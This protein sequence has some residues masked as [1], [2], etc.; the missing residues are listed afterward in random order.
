MGGGGQKEKLSKSLLPT[1][2]FKRQVEF[3]NK[4]ELQNYFDIIWNLLWFCLK[5]IYNS[6]LFTKES[7][8]WF[9]SSI[10]SYLY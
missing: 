9:R 2:N 4:N 7:K 6:L 3:N 1:A 8:H 5:N 10:M